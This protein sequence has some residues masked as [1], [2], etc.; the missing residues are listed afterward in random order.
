MIDDY[1]NNDNIEI[2]PPDPA[3]MEFLKRE[4]ERNKPNYNPRT[5]EFFVKDR[6]LALG[7]A[8]KPLVLTEQ[9]NAQLS[10]YFKDVD[11]LK[12]ARRI[13]HKLE[14]QINKIFFNM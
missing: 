7:I 6:L 2:P 11:S 13:Q 9:Q 8:I 12:K 10:S 14:K 1:F 3:F 5:D 4:C